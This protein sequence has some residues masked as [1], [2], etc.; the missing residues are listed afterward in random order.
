L[1]G[2]TASDEFAFSI[3]TAPPTARQ[4]RL[5]AA[6]IIV[7]FIV[8]AATAPFAATQLARIDSFVPAVEAINFVTDLVTAILLFSKLAYGLCWC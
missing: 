8:F 3:A 1:A 6:L 5:A 7:L 4:R 2:Q